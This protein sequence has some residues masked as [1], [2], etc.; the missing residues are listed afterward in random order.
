MPK[1]IKF[2]EPEE[3]PVRCPECG[4]DTFLLASDNPNCLL[5][6]FAVKDGKFILK[7][8]QCVDCDSSWDLDFDDEVEFI[9][10]DA[11]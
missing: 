3:T 4:C 9:P 7:G 1:I 8:V 2:P 6:G 11:D 10:E 5:D